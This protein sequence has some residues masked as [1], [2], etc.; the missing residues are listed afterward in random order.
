MSYF[1]PMYAT[2]LYAAGLAVVFIAI[3]VRTIRL[4]RSLQIALGDSD[5]ERMMRAMRVH[6]A[7]PFAGLELVP[8]LGLVPLGPDP[9]SRREEFAVLASG[10]PPE[11]GPDGRLRLGEESAIVLQ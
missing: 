8:Q 4:R 5:D 1:T 3:S 10:T 6:A 9:E 2:P 7:P 11:R